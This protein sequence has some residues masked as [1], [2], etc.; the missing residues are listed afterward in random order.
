MNSS[1]AALQEC[2]KTALN[3]ARTKFG[4]SETE[5]CKSVQA[6]RNRPSAADNLKH[7]QPSTAVTDLVNCKKIM[8]PQTCVSKPK[9]SSCNVETLYYNKG[10]KRERESDYSVNL[11]KHSNNFNELVDTTGIEDNNVDDIYSLWKRVSNVTSDGLP[12]VQLELL[13]DTILACIY[14]NKNSFK[15]VFQGLENALNN[16]ESSCSRDE[17]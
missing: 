14:I 9:E 3:Y 4:V 5:N 1:L 17:Y 2:Y 13:Y 15:D 6:L 10:I 11:P 8:T 7:Q 12:V 16:F